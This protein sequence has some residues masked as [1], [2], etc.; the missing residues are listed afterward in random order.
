MCT[1]KPH[2]KQLIWNAS[3]LYTLV[4]LHDYQERFIAAIKFF[5][6]HRML[7]LGTSQYSSAPLTR[8]KAEKHV[9]MPTVGKHVN[10]DDLH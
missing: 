6:F 8:A 9:C 2:P 7:L 1:Y 10:M 3:F 5:I 4:F